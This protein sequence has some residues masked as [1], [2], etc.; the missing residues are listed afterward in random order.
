MNEAKRKPLGLVDATRIGIGAIVGGGILVLAGTA[1][2]H[3]GPRAVLA[4]H[5]PW[6]S[7]SSHCRA[8][9]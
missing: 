9:I 1:F 2:E 4:W 8:S 5:R 6:A 3:T 7:P